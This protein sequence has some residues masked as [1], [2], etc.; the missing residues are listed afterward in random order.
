[1]SPAVPFRLKDDLKMSSRKPQLPE[2][3]KIHFPEG[4]PLRS[5]FSKN[6]GAEFCFVPR[7]ACSGGEATRIPTA[8][9]FPHVIVDLLFWD[10]VK[11]GSRRSAPF[12]RARIVLVWFPKTTFNP[13]SWWDFSLPFALK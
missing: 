13:Q 4:L 8:S 10:K 2:D 9:C 12:S 11:A 3:M 1:M 6:S 5:C 7:L